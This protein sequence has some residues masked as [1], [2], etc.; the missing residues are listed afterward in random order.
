MT[1]SKNIS[2]E[3]KSCHGVLRRYE[4]GI[5]HFSK[6]KNITHSTP[7][8]TKE[9]HDA[10][11]AAQQN[12]KSPILLNLIGLKNIDMNCRAFLLNS[13]PEI[14]TS[15]AFVIDEDPVTKSQFGISNHLRKKIIPIEFFHNED[16]AFQWLSEQ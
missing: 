5:L 8:G 3:N 4:N 11:L 15:I 13:L 6:D 12:T 2:F 1:I 7:E 10:I 16:E 14:S 9:L